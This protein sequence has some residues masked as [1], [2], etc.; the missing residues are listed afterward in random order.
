MKGER[1]YPRN[2]I[3]CIR[4]GKEVK[5]LYPEMDNQILDSAM[6]D[7]GNV[8]EVYG[9]YGSSLDG[10]VYVIGICDDCLKQH[11]HYVGTYL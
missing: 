10:D 9:G 5:L 11:G 3:P 7:E 1:N 4:C 2:S 8:S 6:Y